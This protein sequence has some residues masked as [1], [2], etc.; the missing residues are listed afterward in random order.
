MQTEAAELG[1]DWPDLDGV[2]AKLRE[3]VEELAIAA[4]GDGGNGGECATRCREELG[5][6]LFVLARLAQRMGTD[7]DTALRGA[8]ERFRSRFDH[9]MADAAS[10]PPL[11][12]PERLRVME[13]RWQ[14]AKRR[15]R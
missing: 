1:F 7:A 4:S 8:S 10:L 13:L 11:G 15:E 5:D 12:D 6:V 3:E 14:A 9:V 2:F